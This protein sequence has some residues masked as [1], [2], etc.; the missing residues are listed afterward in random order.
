MMP[1]RIGNSLSQEL[2]SDLV[3]F[4][5]LNFDVF[6]WSYNDMPDISPDMISHWLSIN[7]TIRPIQ[8]KHRAYDLERYE[9]MRRRWIN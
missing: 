7:P 3:A 6:A 9:A 4:L 8:Q 2:R 1:S 5:C